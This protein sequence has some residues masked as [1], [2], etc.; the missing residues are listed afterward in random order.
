MWTLF[1]PM[2]IETGKVIE[3]FVSTAGVVALENEKSQDPQFILDGLSPPRL[4]AYRELDEN[5][6]KLSMMKDEASH[7]WTSHWFH[8]CSNGLVEYIYG[9]Y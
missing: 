5:S 1:Q 4:I 9:N 7:H 6:Q 8:S 2:K 3:S